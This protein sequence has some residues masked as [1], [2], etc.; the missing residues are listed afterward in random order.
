MTKKHKSGIGIRHVRDRA[1]VLLRI[2]SSMC[3]NKIA[4][5]ELPPRFP[6][7]DIMIQKLI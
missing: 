5:F 7:Q 2:L 6:R 1:V 3:V 4:W